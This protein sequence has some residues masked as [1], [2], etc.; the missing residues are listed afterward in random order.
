MWLVDGGVLVSGKELVVSQLY[1]YSVGVWGK[2]SNQSSVSSR[3]LGAVESISRACHNSQKFRICH[4]QS[5]YHF[6]VPRA[7]RLSTYLS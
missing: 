3:A 1:M 2:E 7:H 6:L 4:D 5:G